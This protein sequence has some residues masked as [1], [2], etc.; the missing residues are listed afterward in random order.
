M[1]NL[2]II[3]NSALVTPAGFEADLFQRFIDYTDVQ[4][5]TLKGY[6]VCI[7]HFMRWLNQEGIRQPQREDIKAYKDHLNT[8][9]SEK[10]GAPFSAGTRQQYLRAC[11]H[12]FKWT[13]SEGLYPNIADNIKGVKLK[14]RNHRR[15]NLDVEDARELLRSIDT[16]GEGG[17]RNYAIVLL[18]ITAGLRIIEVQRA[19]I[20]DLQTLSR[21]RILYIQGKGHEEKDDYVKIDTDTATAI[22]TYLKRYRKGAR[23]GDPLFTSTSNNSKGKRI[24]EPT[25]S[26]I[27][28]DALKA[29][30][31][32]SKMITAHSLR[33]T[34]NTLLFKATKDLYRTQKHARHANPATTEIYIHE[35]E[36]AGRHDEQ[37]IADL[38]FRPEK[39]DYAAELVRIM[40]QLP[41]VDQ[42]QLLATAREHLQR[43]QLQRIEKEAI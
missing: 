32:D 8:C 6:T 38:I 13:A 15:K 27:L 3:E 10:T 30:G 43:H 25:L 36:K 16:T 19:D 40:E 37:L 1:N 28:K 29:A 42:Q 4:D 39:Q 11:K 31:F 20:G 26:A 7:R 21:E 5:V 18:C 35:D 41:E 14:N 17:C 2:Q 24:T 9:T 12:F 34:S 22:D 33:H 23:K